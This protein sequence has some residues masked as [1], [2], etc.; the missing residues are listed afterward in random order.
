MVSTKRC[1]KTHYTKP[2]FLH[3]VGSTG[4]IVHS[5]ASSAHYFSCSGGPGAVSTK[6]TLGHVMPYLYFC[7]RWD[8]QVT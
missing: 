5:G 4:H 8:L 7:I 3:L 2:E 1:I 6:S